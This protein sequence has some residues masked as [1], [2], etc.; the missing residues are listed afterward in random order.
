[1]LTNIMITNIMTTTCSELGLLVAGTTPVLLAAPGST[2]PPRLQDMMTVIVVFFRNS[3]FN[4]LHHDFWQPWLLMLVGLW[5]CCWLLL[6]SLFVKNWRDCSLFGFGNNPHSF[7]AACINKPLEGQH[8]GRQESE[9]DDDYDHEY[10]HPLKLRLLLQWFWSEASTR[11]PKFPPLPASTP[12]PRQSSASSASFPMHH[13]SVHVS[14]FRRL[15]VRKP[16]TF[17]SWSVG[18]PGM[19]IPVRN[20]QYCTTFILVIITNHKEATL[21]TTIVICLVDKDPIFFCLTLQTAL[22]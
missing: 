10:Y 17:P 12:T 8:E 5:P 3:A 22:V 9:D 18:F 21:T 2:G 7:V 6:Q 11:R 15:D 20:S 14:T 13:H 19:P 16:F 1:M 4:I